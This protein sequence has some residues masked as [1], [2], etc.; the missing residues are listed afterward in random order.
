MDVVIE[1]QNTDNN[2]MLHAF[3]LLEELTLQGLVF[4]YE[5]VLFRKAFFTLEGVLADLSPEF[6]AGLAMQDY[7]GKLIIE[8]F[9][10]RFNSTM[11]P[12]MDRAD[13]YGSLLSNH[14]VT[15]LSLHINAMLWERTIYGTSMAFTTQVK[16]MSD[17]FRYFNGITS[18]SSS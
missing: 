18:K 11:L 4:P 16:L 10:Q 12:Y 6:N 8:E 7:L 2:P 1:G 3:L 17:M 9:P 13:R 14:D 5:L 15:R